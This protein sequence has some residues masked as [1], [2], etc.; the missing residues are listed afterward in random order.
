MPPSLAFKVANEAKRYLGFAA[1]LMVVFG[2]L[3][4]FSVNIY[5]RIDQEVQHYPSYHFYALGLINALVLAKI[6]LLAEATKM[7][8]RTV[9]R[10]LQDGPLVY[11]ILYRSLL[12]SIVL[13]AAYGLE[14]LLVGAWH[15]KP[16]REVMAEMGGG[17]RGLASFAWVMFVALIP[18]FAY[19]EIGRV[20]GETRLHALLLGRRKAA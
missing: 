11:A 4:L 18:Y 15:G 9:G 19:R 14:E 13:L 17:P 1:Y 7:G 12:F 5:A 8:N 6:M 16:M 3:I 2:T 20:L 10:R